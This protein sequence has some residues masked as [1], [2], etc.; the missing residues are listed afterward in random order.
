MCELG[1]GKI[2]VEA[3][4][5]DLRF[6]EAGEDFTEWRMSGAEFFER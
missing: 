4:V 6:E 3:Y 1:E 2:L 5:E